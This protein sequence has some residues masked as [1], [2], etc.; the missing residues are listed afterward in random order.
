MHSNKICLTEGL[1]FTKHLITLDITV[2]SNKILQFS[3]A[4]YKDIQ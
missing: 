4:L 1:D 2:E 3:Q